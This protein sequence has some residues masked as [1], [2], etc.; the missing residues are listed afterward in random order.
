[1]PSIPQVQDHLEAL[2]AALVKGGLKGPAVIG[3]TEEV[4][5]QPL[6]GIIPPGQ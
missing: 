5:N 3:E 2:V 6:G 4:R 1:M